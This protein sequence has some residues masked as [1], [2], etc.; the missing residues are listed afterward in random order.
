MVYHTDK[1]KVGKMVVVK[2]VDVK[3]LPLDKSHVLIGILILTID[4]HMKIVRKIVL[5]YGNAK[6]SLKIPKR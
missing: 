3:M 4:L 6:K 1:D 2:L 5:E